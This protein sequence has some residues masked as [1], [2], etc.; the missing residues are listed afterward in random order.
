MKD[1]YSFDIDDEGLAA[2]Y[3]AH[4]DTYERIFTRLGLDYVIVNAMAGAMGGSH[5]EEFLP[6]LR[7]R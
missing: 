1:S 5:S 2:A 4:R 3:Q 7:D 6:P